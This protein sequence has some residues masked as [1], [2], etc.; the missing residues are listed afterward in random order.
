MNLQQNGNPAPG[1]NIARFAMDSQRNPMVK[2]LQ[3]C[4]CEVKVPRI[5]P[6]SPEV[7]L[8]KRQ[9]IAETPPKP[10]L[11]S[12]REFHAAR[13][14]LPVICVI[15]AP[16]QKGAARFDRT[17][18]SA[19]VESVHYA[20]DLQKLR[21]SHAKRCAEQMLLGCLRRFSNCSQRLSSRQS[22]YGA[23]QQR[24]VRAGSG[25]HATREGGLFP[26]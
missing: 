22:C 9:E 2:K 15:Y 11:P 24:S 20:D 8:Q 1:T 21:R 23:R 17:S 18:E 13:F 10:M 3:T 4:E 14:N 16:R 25:P 19:S 26:V 6:G 7:K 5:T 12:P